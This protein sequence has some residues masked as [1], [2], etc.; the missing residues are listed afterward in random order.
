MKC[1]I[2]TNWMKCWWK[3]LQDVAKELSVTRLSPN[4]S[5]AICQLETCCVQKSLP[6]RQRAKSCSKS[7]QKVASWATTSCLSCSL[8]QWERLRVQLASWLTGEIMELLKIQFKSESS[9]VVIAHHTAIHVNKRRALHSRKRLLQ[10]IWF[11]TL[12][13]R[14]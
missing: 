5:S 9:N 8:P 4:T 10:L 14:T 6:A 1:Q 7:W 11:S 13:A 3:C 12:N 2:D